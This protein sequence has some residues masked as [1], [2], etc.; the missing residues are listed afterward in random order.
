MTISGDP[1]LGLHTIED[2]VLL[3]DPASVE[4]ILKKAKSINNAHVVNFNPTLYGGG[5]SE[6]LTPFTLLMNTMGIQEDWRVFQ[7]TPE[8]FLLHKRDS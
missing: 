1:F 4:R 2:Y 7:G 3:I 5:A 6:I 8:F